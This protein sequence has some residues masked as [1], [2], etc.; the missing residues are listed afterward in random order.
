VSD[1]PWTVI[2]LGGRSAR[3]PEIRASVLGLLERA[4]LVPSV[5]TLRDEDG[6]VAFDPNAVLA[7]EPLLPGPLVLAGMRPQFAASLWLGDRAQIRLELPE[8]GTVDALGDA[9]A[10]D[11]LPDL[12]W[13]WAQWNVADAGVSPSAARFLRDVGPDPGEG[14][15]RGWGIRTWLSNDWAEELMPG[16]PGAVRSPVKVHR[17]TDE[18]VRVDLTSNVKDREAVLTGHAVL[19][20]DGTPGEPLR[21][22]R[23]DAAEIARRVGPGSVLDGVEI[24]GADLR[25]RDLFRSTWRHAVIIDSDFDG[26]SLARTS[27]DEAQ[28]DQVSLRDCE[29]EYATF[30][31]A[32]LVSSFLERARIMRADLRGASLI[33]CELNATIA[34]Q[35]NLEAALLEDCRLVG[36]DLTGAHLDRATLRRCDLSGAQLGGD[37]LE[38]AIMEDCDL[39][40]SIS[41]E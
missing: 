17:L 26:A 3:Q 23:L 33:N 25:G 29:A 20:N 14:T 6:P 19:A 24:E 27:F 5:M 8:S 35:A 31:A 32:D 1:E 38:G 9:L 30:V 13:A 40:D 41:S 18:L 2:C 16:G 11:V 34:R 39:T 28:L 21:R 10:I 4:G 22:R 15:F 36:A 12:M 37:A 7:P